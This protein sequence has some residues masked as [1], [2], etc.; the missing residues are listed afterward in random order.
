M[1]NSSAAEVFFIGDPCYDGCGESI[2]VVGDWRSLPPCQ[3][4]AIHEKFQ[5]PHL[6]TDESDDHTDQDATESNAVVAGGPIPVLHP[7]SQDVDYLNGTSLSPEKQALLS[8]M[9][10]HFGTSDS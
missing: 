8:A 9:M 1:P 10:A 4:S 6:H 5:R 2:Q 3:W 7:A